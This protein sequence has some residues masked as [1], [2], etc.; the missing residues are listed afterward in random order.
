MEV[1][2]ATVIAATSALLSALLS[3][4]A[5][6]ESQTQS[7]LTHQSNFEY[8]R[9]YSDALTNSKQKVEPFIEEISQTAF[10]V[11]NYIINDVDRFSQDRGYRE[12]ATGHILNEIGCHL[13]NAF[14]YE[15]P[16]QTS[17]KLYSRFRVVFDL[18]MDFDELKPT[19]SKINLQDS[20]NNW[21]NEYLEIKLRNTKEFVALLSRFFN[22]IEPEQREP[23]YKFCL[24]ASESV[25]CLLKDSQNFFKSERVKL[26]NML[27]SNE[28]EEVKISD[29]PKLANEF[30]SFTRK[31]EFLENFSLLEYSIVCDYPSYKLSQVLLI[32]MFMRLLQHHSSWG[33]YIGV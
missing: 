32:I 13:F 15:M 19:I 24:E 29:Y 17:L 27:R 11:L 8:V 3:H 4:Q 9:K 30:K 21:K 28:L 31:L 26:E 1:M 12:T 20:Y 18:E 6:R 25:F 2:I 10:T 33:N 5:N 7:L 16:W 23:I 22:T 14:S